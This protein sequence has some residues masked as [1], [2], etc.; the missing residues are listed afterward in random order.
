MADI[1]GVVSLNEVL[2][3]QRDSEWEDPNNVW[4]F[5][6]DGGPEYKFIDGTVTPAPA[7]TPLG[8]N[9]VK[10]VTD[11]DVEV[12][13]TE[14]PSLASKSIRGVVRGICTTD[15]EVIIVTMSNTHSILIYKRTNVFCW[16]EKAYRYG[17]SDDPND[18]PEGA[19]TVI[20]YANASSDPTWGAYTTVDA[21]NQKICVGS[22]SGCHLWNLDGTGYVNITKTGTGIAADFGKICACGSGKVAI[23][24]PLEDRTSSGGT[25]W[26]DSG[27]VYVYNLDGT[28]EYKLQPSETALGRN[29]LNAS[30]TPNGYYVEFGTSV[31]V[32]SNRIIVG[33]EGASSSSIRRYNGAVFTY[34]LDGT[35][36]TWHFARD[37]DLEF[38]NY[39][40][41]ITDTDRIG[42]F[43]FAKYGRFYTGTGFCDEQCRDNRY[44]S[45]AVYSSSIPNSSATGAYQMT[46][47]YK[48]WAYDDLFQ[49]GDYFGERHQVGKYRSYSSHFYDQLREVTM[50]VATGTNRLYYQ[51]GAGGYTGNWREV[52]YSM[53][54][55]YASSAP[56]FDAIERHI[57]IGGEAYISS[58]P[59]ENGRI[60]FWP[61]G[62]EDDTSQ[63]TWQMMD[64]PP[65]L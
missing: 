56:P 7:A 19:L 9:Y 64:R 23:G 43:V 42:R 49:D 38:A 11:Y 46:N 61:I 60:G 5:P 31:A 30:Y 37:P 10:V 25:N 53:S 47:I 8:P 4:I 15:D 59:G 50:A 22:S 13:H 52:F 26:L 40:D 65:L 27:A 3:L 54:N 12:K 51:Y 33:A 55:Q 58:N 32:D 48:D 20:S 63:Y 36:E 1:R 29:G 17:V 18:Y 24:N 21:G 44:N 2:D 16:D 45:G 57:V 28:G 39:G 6:D 35:G 34:N 14:I 62:L 41:G